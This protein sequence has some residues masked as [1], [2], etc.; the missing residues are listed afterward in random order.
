MSLHPKIYSGDMQQK[1]QQMKQTAQY[2][3]T[4]NVWINVQVHS[5]IR[6]NMLLTF[7]TR[8]IAK[9][10]PPMCPDNMDAGAL[11]TC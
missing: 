6:S 11:D 7:Q 5:N 4:D 3:P 8:C 9:E 1:Q 2:T 10:F